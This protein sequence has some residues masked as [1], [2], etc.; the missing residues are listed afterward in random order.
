MLGVSSM[1]IHTIH[2]QI[3]S[4]LPVITKIAATWDALNA[5]DIAQDV[6]LKLLKADPVRVRLTNSSWLYRVVRNAAFDYLRRL[7]R[8]RRYV[9]DRLTVDITGSVCEPGND[10]E[11]K[12]L[13]PAAKNVDEDMEYYLIPRVKE[14][15]LAIPREQRRAVVLHLSGYSYDEIADMTASKMG[16]V[17]SRLHYGRKRLQ[18]LLG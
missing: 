11:C 13:V 16:T 17:R 5:D 2:N 10:G 14:A 4:M 8:E 6:A 18:K 1:D 15:L 12:Y 3:C 9:D 7:Q